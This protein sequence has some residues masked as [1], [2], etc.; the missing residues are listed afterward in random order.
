MRQRRMC[1]ARAGLP[2][3][4]VESVAEV[5]PKSNAKRDNLGTAGPTPNERDSLH[6][7]YGPAA[8]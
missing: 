8:S 7:I 6:A 1:L 5:P 4:A 2:A 3:L